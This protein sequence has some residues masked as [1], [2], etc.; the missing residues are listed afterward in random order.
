MKAPWCT[1][2]AHDQIICPLSAA[3]AQP[4]GHTAAQPGPQQGGLLPWTAAGGAGPG[5]G[6]LGIPACAS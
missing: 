5:R 1:H 6:A 2:G 3:R 4:L